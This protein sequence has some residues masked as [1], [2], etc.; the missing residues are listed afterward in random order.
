MKFRY[1]LIQQI[2]RLILKLFWNLKIVGL[3]DIEIKNGSIICANHQTAFDPP[4]LGAILPVETYYLAKSELFKNKI[5]KK[6][7]TGL[8]AIPINRKGFA[9]AS[10]VKCEE[11]IR[12]KKNVVI[13]PEGTRKSATVKAGVGRIAIKTEAIIYPVKIL[14]IE[15]FKDCFLRKKNLTFVFKKP[16]FSTEYK[17]FSER[18]PDYKKIAQKIL[19]KINEP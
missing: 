4:F 12:N 3:E 11:L 5:L 17:N 16:I 19:D 9:R 18:K 10:I 2:I 8:N 7:I 14:N 1:K 13:F 6:I 15:N